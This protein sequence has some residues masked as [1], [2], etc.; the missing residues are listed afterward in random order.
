M[1][2]C[3]CSEPDTICCCFLAGAHGAEGY[4]N[5]LF[6]HPEK[7]AHSNDHSRDA[8]VLVNEHVIDIAD[9]V[10]GRI[11]NILLVEVGYRG[12]GGLAD[13]GLRRTGGGWGRLLR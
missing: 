8:T 7:A 4:G 3:S 10:V 1:L 5:V 9:L 11:I 2:L 13:E 6:A 12:A